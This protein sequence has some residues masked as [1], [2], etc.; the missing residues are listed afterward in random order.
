MAL[1]AAGALTF[2]G[3]GVAGLSI[4]PRYLTI[5]AVVVCLFAA[6]ALTRNRVVLGIALAAGLAF[7]AIKATTF[8]R[9]ASELR[10]GR[11]VHADLVATLDDPTDPCGDR[12]RRDQLPD[13]SPGPRSPL[14][15]RYGWCSCLSREPIDRSE[16]GV[17]IVVTG[18]KSTK[19]YGY[20]DG[21]PRAT[22]EPPAGWRRGPVHGR[23]VSYLR[24]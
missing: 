5:P 19:R 13:V 21:V 16:T 3:T 1:F 11:A 4:L 23:F 17:A 2:A 6:Y 9:L 10:F 22:N 24:C 7:V 15:P 8:E 12:L 18:E 20:A 14:A